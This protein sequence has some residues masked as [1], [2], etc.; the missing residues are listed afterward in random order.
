MAIVGVTSELLVVLGFWGTCF[1][2]KDEQIR[3]NNV[4]RV[5]T[6]DDY[7]KAPAHS[8][9][10]AGGCRS[11]IK[12]QSSPERPLV[13]I[14]TIVLNR[15]ET[16]PQ[17]IMSVLNQSYPNI[18]Y[19]VV[20][21]AST[22]GTLEIIK[23]FDD[24]IDLW[25]S[26]PDR[27]SSD[28]QNKAISLARGDM[29]FPLSSDDWIDPDFIE[30]AVKAIL[31]SGVDFVFGDMA[32]YKDEKFVSVLKGEKDY[33]KSLMSGNP[34]FNFPSMLIKRA[35]YQKI[36]LLDET[37]KI[38]NDYEWTLRLHLAGGNGFYE[39]RLMVHRRIGGIADHHPFRSLLGQLKVL[40]QHGLPTTKATVILLPYFVR[41]GVGYFVKLFL[42]DII[43]KKLKRAVGKASSVPLK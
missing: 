1:W 39:S 4:N 26:E 6:I 28:A 19:I 38:S 14:T 42:P 17:T 24:K 12:R 36:G 20:D 10:Q 23:Q 41:I 18:E 27:G 37:Y 25:I 31:S 7:L 40:R 43:Y 15:K 33:A 2:N 29:V 34:R 9:R 30:L 32:M 35:C 13:S 16:L 22:D 3:M 11:A 8:L 21:G 5:P